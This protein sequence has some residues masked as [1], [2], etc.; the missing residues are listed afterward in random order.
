MAWDVVKNV[1]AT[2][3]RD[4]CV[5]TEKRR[6]VRENTEGTATV[7]L[8]VRP[9]QN[10]YLV[11]RDEYFLENMAKQFRADLLFFL[12]PFSRDERPFEMLK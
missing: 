12:S 7:A 6:A 11:V 4:D 3:L 1:Y 9:A 2:K 5:G 10:L 8:R